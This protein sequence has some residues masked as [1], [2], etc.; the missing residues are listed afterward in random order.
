MLLSGGVLITFRG[1]LDLD[2]QR[3]LRGAAKIASGL[4]LCAFGL[5][6]WLFL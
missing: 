5:A 2:D 6:N 4:A 3:R 1:R